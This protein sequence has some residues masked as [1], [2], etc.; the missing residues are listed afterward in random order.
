M[1]FNGLDLE[2]DDCGLLQ[3]SLSELIYPARGMKYVI[4]KEIL[5]SVT[6]Y[7]YSS[8]TVYFVYSMLGPATHL[9]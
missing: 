1:M 9:A 7:A 8:V 3:G 6:L 4:G 5:T 2:G